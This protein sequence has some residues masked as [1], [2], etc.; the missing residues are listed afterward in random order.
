MVIQREDA[1]HRDT[2]VCSLQ[3]LE[4]GDGCPPLDA[5]DL[6][7]SDKER[8]GPSVIATILP[9]Q[10]RKENEKLEREMPAGGR[11]PSEGEIFQEQKQPALHC[12]SADQRW[13]QWDAEETPALCHCGSYNTL[14]W[15]MRVEK[16]TTESLG[17]VKGWYSTPEPMLQTELSIILLEHSFHLSEPRERTNPISRCYNSH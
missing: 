9:S 15:E 7:N 17:T 12:S 11:K 3:E 14:D 8:W 4:A 2:R 10:G 1:G 6:V 13:P 5:E 16:P